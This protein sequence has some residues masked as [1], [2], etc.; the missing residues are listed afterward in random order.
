MRANRASDL[1]RRD[2]T[3]AIVLAGGAGTRLRSVLP[4]MPKPMAPIQGR[5]FLAYLLDNLA[6]QGIRRVVLSVGYRRDSILNFFGGGYGGL[7]IDFAIEE[8]PL[9][10]GGAIARTLPLLN[11]PEGFVL[12]G[13]TFLQL[14]FRAMAA[15]YGDYGDGNMMMA[16][17]QVPD[18][19]RY[20]RVVVI[21]GRVRGFSFGSGGAGTINAGVYLMPRNLFDGYT[22][23]ASFSFERDFLLPNVDALQPRG[24][25]SDGAFIDIGVP[26]GYEEARRFLSAIR[27]ARP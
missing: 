20:G 26:E 22:L 10:T 5:P 16:L 14:D 15:A 9:G 17:H 1:R 23:P 19:T 6:A 27:A 25:P 13:D 8:Q 11:G 12:N 3:E 7:A 2:V 24:F 18:A 4:D 21:D